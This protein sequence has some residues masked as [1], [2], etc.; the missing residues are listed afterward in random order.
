MN[1]SELGNGAKSMARGSTFNIVRSALRRSPPK[2][3][4]RPVS[5]ASPAQRAKVTDA[6]SIVSAEP[7]GPP[8]HLWPRGRG[9]CDDPLCVI[10]L[11]PA[12]HRRFDDGDLDLL[13]Y[14]LAHGLVGELQHALGHA[15]GNLIALLQR[16]TGVRWVPGDREAVT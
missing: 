14:L 12:E 8:A 9:G 11:T 13:P 16:V 4:S 15:D 1:R 10:P 7:A 6:R 3:R 5:P 2:P